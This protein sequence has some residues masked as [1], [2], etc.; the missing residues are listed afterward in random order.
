MT[1]A[2]LAKVRAALERQRD[3]YARWSSYRSM[4]V[5][6]GLDRAIDVMAQEMAQR[7]GVDLPAEEPAEPLPLCE[8]LLTYDTSAPVESLFPVNTPIIRRLPRIPT[9]VP[10]HGSSWSRVETPDDPQP[11]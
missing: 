5:R 11:A 2:Q 10:L 8:S 9:Q 3:R 1:D 4:M 6:I 7:S